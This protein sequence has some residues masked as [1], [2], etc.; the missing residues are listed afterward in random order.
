[1]KTQRGYRLVIVAA[2]ALSSLALGPKPLNP[3]MLGFTEETAAQE[4]ELERRFDALLRAENLREW[5]QLATVE[6]I[7][8]GSPHN[9][10][11]ADWMV[12]R[13]RSWGYEADL[14]EY[15]VLFP[16]PR[17]RELELLEPTSF[18]ARLREPT[19]AEDRTSGIEENRLPT[20]NAYSA[21]GDV[22]GELVYVNY[23][24]PDDYDEL[25]RLG[26]DVR[27]KLVIARYGGS[28]RGIKP[29]VAHEHGA[30][31]VILYSDPRDDGYYQGDV[32]PA[33]PFRMDGGVQRGSVLDMPQYPGDPLTPGVGATAEAE[34]LRREDAPTI[35]KIPVLPISY[36]DALPFLEA[37]DGPVAPAE[38]RG[39]LPITYHLGPGPARA[40]LHVDFDWELTPAYNVIARV[41]GSEF[42]DEWVVR[43]NHRDGWAIGAGDPTSGMVALLEEARAIGE[44]MKTGWRPKRTII[45]AGWD[46]EEP[47]LLGSTEWAEDHGGELREKA[48]VYINTDGSG[49]GF[50]SM[51][52]SHTLEPFINQV[53]RDVPDPQT[54]VSVW[55][56]ARAAR[57]VRGNEKTK[58]EALDRE[59]LRI[60]PLGSGSDYTPFLQHLGIPSLNLGF[61]GENRGG[62]YH[63]MF[64][65]FDY[66]TRFGDPGF[67]YGVALAK[68]AGRTTLR[69]ANADVL[70]FQ[71]GSFA[72]NVG[73]Y[74]EEVIELAD[75]M[76]EETERE[77]R[78]I[79][80]RMYELAADPTKTY[81]PPESQESVPYLNF[82]PVKNAF[83]EL[84]G[85]SESYDESLTERMA[86]GGLPAARAAELNRV[87]MSTER[88]MT[89]DE[90]LPRRPW[91]RHQIYAPGFYTGYGVKTLPGIREAIEERKWD[92]AAE[93]MENA[94]AALER[95]T[96]AIEQATELL[97]G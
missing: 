34:R 42:P 40:R 49:R 39:A 53:A 14:S 48:A 81:H 77:N 20:Y 31:G 51:G 60:S 47:A 55:E 67:V 95:V 28:W 76:R 96:R 41:R 19:L 68:T 36:S 7:Y 89:R 1:M 59:D 79:R 16:T 88:L 64:D 56:R 86:G 61:G 82:A 27:G 92:E 62:S 94:A 9:K 85:A 63:S 70:P 35:M 6:P 71:F 83:A 21:D 75:E 43:G 87:L 52:G 54:G 5:M 24:I 29:K 22:T 26:I 30:L 57:A 15:R 37:L 45:Y 58:K 84:E 2:V 93:Q 11:M 91:F 90:G 80:E 38:W 69:F 8:V 3:P 4:L 18:T 33:G 73:Q 78:L 23:G 13:F 50:L 10:K 32:Y 72:E 74:L 44:L 97:K 46:A 12:E 65:S 66:Y 17:I 25:E